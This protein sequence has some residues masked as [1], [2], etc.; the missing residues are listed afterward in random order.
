VISLMLMGLATWNEDPA[1][2]AASRSSRRTVGELLQDQYS[3]SKI[4]SRYCVHN[5]RGNGRSCACLR[6]GILAA[7]GGQSHAP[8]RSE[9]R[10]GRKFGGEEWQKYGG[11]KKRGKCFPQPS[12]NLDIEI[13]S[14][15]STT[16]YLPLQ[17][18]LSLS[19]IQLGV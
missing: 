3:G 7:F 1:I 17:S 15:T 16:L 19:T 12:E 2:V 5:S 13:I 10:T 14:L 9:T 8:L 18:F 6:C 4:N 11:R